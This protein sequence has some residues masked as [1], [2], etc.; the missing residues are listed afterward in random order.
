MDMATHTLQFTD[1]PNWPGVLQQHR[2]WLSAVVYARVRDHHAVEEVLQETA[3]AASKQHQ[4]A[5]DAE[6]VCKWLYR[7]AVRQAMLYRRG[8][9]RN[10]TKLNNVVQGSVRSDA[11]QFDPYR[12]VLASEQQELVRDALARLPARDCEILMLKYNE[13]WSCHEMSTRL[14]VSESAL[15]SRLLRARNALRAQL[16]CLGNDWDLR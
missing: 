1:S 9:A 14:G 8:Q 13:G 15:K 4:L 3:L 11:H 5:P 10:K 2:S 16:L 6:G 12:M 7:V